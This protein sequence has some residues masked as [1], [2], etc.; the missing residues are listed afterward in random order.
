MRLPHDIWRDELDGA[1]LVGLRWVH[2]RRRPSFPPLPFLLA[3]AG[4]AL[5]VLAAFAWSRP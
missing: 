3:A 1:Q 2:P 5:G 4:L